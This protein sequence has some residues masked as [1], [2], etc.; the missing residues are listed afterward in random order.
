ME[1]HKLFAQETKMQVYVCDPHRSWQW[2]TNENT[3][4][5]IRDFFR[6]RLIL[7][8]F[9]GRKFNMLRNSWMRGQEKHWTA[10]LLKNDLRNYCCVKRLNLLDQ[11]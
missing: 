1:E 4:M 6:S 10:L 8:N 11:F 3:N 7:V 9:K 5:L 2:G